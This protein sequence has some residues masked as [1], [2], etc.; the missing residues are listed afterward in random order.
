MTAITDPNGKTTGFE[1]DE[2]G[3]LKAVVD[4]AQKRTEYTY[5]SAGNLKTVKDA[6]GQV[7]TYEYDDKG[8]RKAV[9]RP[10]TKRSSIVCDD[11]Q[12]TVTITDFNNKTVKYTYNDQNQVVSKQY[13][14]ASGATVSVTYTANGLEETITDS[15]GATV[16]K[17]D[18][19]GQLISRKDPVGPYLA[20]G[21]SIEYKYESGQVSEVKTPTRTANYTYYTEGDSLGRL[22]TVSTP[23]MGTV[24][25]VYYPDGN[26]WKTFYPNNLLE[27][28]TY[29]DL[30]R[31]DVVK[32]ASIDPVTQQELQVISSFDYLVDGVGNR[33]EV[34]ENSGRKVEYKYDDLHRLLEEK[35]TN[36]PGGNNRVVTYTY[37]AVGNRLTKTDSVSGVT[38]T[39]TYNN[40]N[41]LDF[42]TDNN[43][44]TDY[45][46]DDNGNL[47]SEVTGNNSTVYRWVNDGENRLVG[48]TVSE[49]GVTRNVGY[50]YNAQGVRVGKVVDG[51][52]TRYLIDE[53]QP[54]SQVV[55]EYDA[56]GNARGSYVYGY[57]LI[58]KLQGNQASFYHV[59][60]L[61][62]TR[63]L[64][65]GLGAVT[66]TYSYDAFG[67]SIV[68]T[69]G[70]NNPYLFAG[71]QRDAETGL[72]YL[73]ARYYDPFVGRFVS[74]DAYEGSLNDPLSLHDYLYAHAN[75]VVN[76]DPSG[77]F[78]IA[79][80]HA[81]ESIRNILAG[82]QIDIGSYL[83][84]A[85]LK[86]GDYGIED[87]L[88]DWGLSFGFSVV[89]PL[90]PFI[91]RLS[92]LR[93]LTRT[94]SKMRSGTGLSG[95]QIPPT[96][97]PM[98]DILAKNTDVY[99]Q[100]INNLQKRGIEV[101]ESSMPVGT[102]AEI[103][104][105]PKSTRLMIEIDPEQFT[106]LDLLHESRHFEQI[107]RIELQ[108]GQ[109]YNFNKADIAMFERGAY[110]YELRM[111]EKY[112]FT[113]EYK[114]FAEDRIRDYWDRGMRQKMDKSKSFRNRFNQT[115]K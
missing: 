38:T 50:Q 20:S 101:V 78:T 95:G 48:A 86:G 75:P 115:W 90:L 57:D 49:G 79:E 88:S 54:Y 111:A 30:G 46:Y 51:V 37:D 74:A 18:D 104:R 8:R 66:D 64:T 85:T 3:Q 83:V 113:E 28:R 92:K 53:L 1:Y 36:D 70:S 4:A 22:K 107:R 98:F 56:A 35:V 32:T 87:L 96:G 68:S 114:S 25:Y 102:H 14:N 105:I 31:L 99:V 9:I 41:Q 11:A 12:K 55:E 47:I 2:K 15:R 84:S 71:Q 67:N 89:P 19:L 63:L 62:S 52:E 29:D 44:V 97:N 6:L 69:G 91:A 110:E 23:D 112:N 16:Y 42:L 43:V 7:T 73:R 27:T 61:G 33:K 65:N 80:M 40:L 108:S 106:Y 81:A 5:D 17:Y 82:I 72:D 94:F 93:P 10:D 59:D 109:P 34:L 77:Y 76:T 24:T 26:L 45:T 103:S 39:Y 58:G 13:Q 21:N 100:W 60:G